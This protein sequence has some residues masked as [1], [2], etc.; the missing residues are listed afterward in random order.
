MTTIIEDSLFRP[1]L[2]ERKGDAPNYYPV[3][4]LYTTSMKIYTMEWNDAQVSHPTNPTSPMA[5]EHYKLEQNATTRV[6]Q[7]DILLGVKLYILL[8]RFY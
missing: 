4:L 7:D 5:Y 1:F 3:S 6:F 8:I 2:K